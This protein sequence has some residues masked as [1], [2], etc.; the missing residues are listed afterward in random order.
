MGA[1][2]NKTL[3]TYMCNVGQ[4]DRIGYYPTALA[5]LDKFKNTM[6][7][8]NRWTSDKNKIKNKK[9]NKCPIVES[10]P[11]CGNNSCKPPCE[12]VDVYPG[13]KGC[14]KIIDI[15]NYFKAKSYI[16]TVGSKSYLSG[17]EHFFK[18]NKIELIYH[19]YRHPSYTQLFE[20]YS[21]YACILDLIF[22]EGYKSLSIIKS[23]RIVD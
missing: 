21:D 15:C 1:N 22:N 5:N 6:F 10:T 20:P 12:N 8:T 7:Y 16:T 11:S 19:N 3:Y 2:N 23:G 17:N 18:K 9:D 4:D 13:Q 14:Q